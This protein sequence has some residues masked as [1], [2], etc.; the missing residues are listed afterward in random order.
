MEQEHREEN[1][2]E[3][4]K[5]LN[6]YFSSKIYLETRDLHIYL[7]ITYLNNFFKIFSNLRQKQK[8]IALYFI[9]FSLYLFM[10]LFNLLCTYY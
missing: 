5:N 2:A 10:Y 9:Y 3:L 1:Y 7:N 4:W 6:N 8:P